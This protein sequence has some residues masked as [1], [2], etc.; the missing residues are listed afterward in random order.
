MSA[1][2]D[3][4]EA[5]ILGLLAERRPGATICPSDAARRFAGDDEERW[6]PQMDAA[7]A[8]ARRLVARGEVEITQGGRVVDPVHAR[9][10]IRIRRASPTGT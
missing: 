7:R 10:P 6:R 3:A 4:M 5:V 2:D 9:G 8:A 1:S